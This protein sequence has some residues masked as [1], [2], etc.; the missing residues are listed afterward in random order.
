MTYI[1]VYTQNS[2]LI[3]LGFNL[4]S[5]LPLIIYI[6]YFDKKDNGA[7]L[8]PVGGLIIKFLRRFR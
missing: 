3:L 6:S 7:W 4:F 1:P 5:M 8:G 2:I